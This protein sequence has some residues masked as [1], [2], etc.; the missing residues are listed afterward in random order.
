MDYDKQKLI[1]D[2]YAEDS[3]HGIEMVAALFAMISPADLRE[4]FLVA[5]VEFDK[6][7]GLDP[8]Y[9]ASEA[10]R[11][12]EMQFFAAQLFNSAAALFAE[13]FDGFV[14]LITSHADGTVVVVEQDNLNPAHL[15]NPNCLPT[16]TIVF[17]FGKEQPPIIN[18]K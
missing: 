17:S 9:G 6:K 7:L 11:K 13:T 3:I 10:I 18:G 2:Q 15:Q 14:P 12:R 1:F 5:P 16:R 8:E 4:H